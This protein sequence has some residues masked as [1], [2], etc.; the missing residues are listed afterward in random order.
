MDQYYPAGKV[1]TVKYPEI[2]RRLYPEEF[3]KAQHLAWEAG[4]RRLDARRPQRF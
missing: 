4:L 3:R 2:N 1:S